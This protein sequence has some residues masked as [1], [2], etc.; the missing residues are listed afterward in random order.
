M[1]LSKKNSKNEQ[2]PKT[3]ETKTIVIQPV[4]TKE[5]KSSQYSEW[6]YKYI[7]GKKLVAGLISEIPAFC[8]GFSAGHDIVKSIETCSKNDVSKKD[9]T[10]CIFKTIGK[11][12]L[13]GVTGVVAQ[14]CVYDTISNLVDLSDKK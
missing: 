1:S 12:A 8:S 13:K 10:K 4:S 14:K 3:V 2:Q 11:V 6:G 7:N 5:E 9:K